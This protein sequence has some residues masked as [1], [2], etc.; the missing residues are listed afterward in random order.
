M[1]SVGK[2]IVQESCGY[3]GSSM[4]V[5]R[6]KHDAEQIYKH[7]S[8]KGNSYYMLVMDKRTFTLITKLG[9]PKESQ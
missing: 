8:S 5:Q 2:I 6:I 1:K 3:T 9:P 4:W 7:V